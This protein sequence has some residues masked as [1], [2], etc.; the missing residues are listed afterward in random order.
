MPQEEINYAIGDIEA[1]E[2]A[3][4]E[5]ESAKINDQ[6]PSPVAKEEASG[7]WNEF[8]DENSKIYKALKNVRRGRDIGVS[9]AESYNKI[10]E[11]IGMPSVPLIALELIKKL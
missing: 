2:E 8:K 5:A 1:F 10:A 6:D 4:Q 7:F 11:N 9:L 3:L